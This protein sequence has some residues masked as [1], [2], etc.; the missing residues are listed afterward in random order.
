VFSTRI[1]HG[2]VDDLERSLATAAA[3][4]TQAYL[5][6]G[7]RDRRQPRRLKPDGI[8]LQA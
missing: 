5:D 3:T 7:G 2:I 1:E 6:R 4:C 8:F